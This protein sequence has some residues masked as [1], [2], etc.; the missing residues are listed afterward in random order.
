MV[1][2]VLLGHG[3][4]GND[5]PIGPLNQYFNASLAQLEFDP[6]KAR[7]FLAKAGLDSLSLTLSTSHAAFSG[8]CQAADLFQSSAALAGIEIDI[9]EEASD[10][11]WADAWLQSSFAN[12]H[13]FGRATEDWMFSTAY[14]D[15]ATWGDCG[16]Q[17]HARFQDLLLKARAELD[18]ETRQDHYFEM[19]EILRDEGS[20]LIPMFANFLQATHKGIKTAETIGNLWPMDNARMAERWSRA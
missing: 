16:L 13:W 14:A 20:T 2:Q 10:G 1:E 8:A 4:V 7:H 3:E 18:S 9:M 12:G 11:Y 19:Q 17:S 5:T 15:R 6:D